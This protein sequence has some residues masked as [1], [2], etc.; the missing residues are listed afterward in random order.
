MI[1]VQGHTQLLQIVV[2][3]RAAGGLASGLDGRQQQ[4]HQDP[5]DGD[6][7]Q[8]FDERESEPSLLLQV[9]HNGNPWK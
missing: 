2:A 4:G 3:L 1:I 9:E 5:D 8:Q 6:H 7:H